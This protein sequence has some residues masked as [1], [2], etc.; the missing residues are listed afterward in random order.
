MNI[1]FLSGWFP[2]PPDNGSRLRISNIIEGL[3]SQ[4]DITLLSFADK[5]NGVVDESAA[6]RFCR[7]VHV[8]P[9]RPFNQRNHRAQLGFLSS[10]PRSI[11]ATFSPEMESSVRRLLSAKQFDLVIASQLTAASYAFLFKGLP[12]LFEESELG[13]FYEQFARATSIRHRIR[14]GLTWTKHRRYVANLLCYFRACTVVSEQE[15]ELMRRCAPK[16]Q[17]VD[18]I[19]NCIALDDYRDLHAPNQPNTLIFT[20][21]FR[22]SA[23]YEAMVWFLDQVYPFI[24]K[25]IPDVRLTI[26]GDR[27]DLPVPSADNVTYTG[28]VDDVRPLVASSSVSL[29]PMRTGGGTRLK[30]L[31]AMALRTPVVATSKGAEGL[32]VRHGQHVLIAD[33]PKAFAD[34]AVRLLREPDLGRR[35]AENAYQL[36]RA[37]YDWAAV[38]PRFLNLVDR[39]AHN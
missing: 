9:T 26:T 38:M 1:L 19:P 39:V 36:V 28:V 35:L 34:E 4:H 7:E 13:V 8:V 16:F 2:Y 17:S 31:E 21:S 25:E 5:Q 33:E 18:V 22:Y 14:Y 6:R 3:A 23:N 11:H 10:T 37:E 15:R 24:R 20:G 29:A 32:D 27:A 30:I 12:A